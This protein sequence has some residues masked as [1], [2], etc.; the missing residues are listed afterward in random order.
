MAITPEDFLGP[1]L[2]G[3]VRQ[4]KDH[5]A[6]VRERF[7]PAQVAEAEAE[8]SFFE[9]AL[10]YL[11]TGVM[12]QMHAIPPPATVD[13]LIE[14]L[15]QS[16]ARAEEAARRTR[17]ASMPERSAAFDAMAERSRQLRTYVAAFRSTPI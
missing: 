4:A 11:D 16:I 13:G 1:W 8:L 10:A 2:D 7:G 6:F 12:P 5:L 14:H 3:C 17:E 9:G 15:G